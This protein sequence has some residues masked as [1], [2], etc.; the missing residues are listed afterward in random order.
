MN[1]R[2]LFLNSSKMVIIL[3]VS[4]FLVVSCS[5][6]PYRMKRAKRLYRQGQLYLSKG[7]QEKAIKKFE[8]SLS[9]SRDIGFKPGVAHNLNEMAIIKT[10][11][12]EHVKAR[13]L[14]TEAMDIYKQLNM[15]PE[16]SKSLNNIAGT[17]MRERNFKEAIKQYEDLL[18][19]DRQTQNKFGVG[20][21]LYNIGLIYQN[22][23]RRYEDAKKKYLEA[24]AVFHELGHEKYIQLV[25]QNLANNYGKGDG[26]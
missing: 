18:K 26:Q 1:S 3:W 19:W 15:K 23:L 11:G 25:E 16:V 22:H 7:N 14:H 10:I 4:V 9:L 20:I 2:I 21:T 17:Y 5:T 24:L 8:E 12:G 13:E 6:R